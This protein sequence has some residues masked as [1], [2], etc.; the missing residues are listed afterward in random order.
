ME[1]H[2]IAVQNKLF[3]ELLVTIYVYRMDQLLYICKLMIRTEKT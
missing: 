3:T 2:H 1:K